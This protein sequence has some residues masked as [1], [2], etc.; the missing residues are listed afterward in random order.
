[1]R[2]GCVAAVLLFYTVACTAPAV[3]PLPTPTPDLDA[4]LEFRVRERV[5]VEVRT[6]MAQVPTATAIPT[7]TPFPTAT[8]IP[9]ATPAPTVTPYPTA[10]PTQRPT[11]TPRPT[12][13]R[14]PTP[15]PTATPTIADQSKRLEPWVVR[16]S[17]FDSIGTGF[18]IRDP[19]RSSDWYIVTNAHVVGGNDY[20]AVSWYYHGIPDL[21]RVRVLG[22]DEVTDVALLDVG[23]N[24]FDWSGTEYPNGL[25]YLNDWGDGIRI[26]ADVRQGAEVLA[27][28]FPVGGGGRT[29][30]S[31]IV[32]V[33]NVRDQPFSPGV[34]YI[35]TDTAI[36]P[37]NSG[38][39]LMTR[40]GEIIGMNTWTRTDLENVGYALPMREILSRF[41]ALKNGQRLI[42]ATPTPVPTLIPKADFTDGSFLAVLTWDDGWYNTNQDDSICVD[43]VW[44]SGNRYEWRG[45]CEFGGRERNGKFYAWY[46]QQWLEAY[47]IELENR[48]Y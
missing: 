19:S 36:N 22:V 12:A 48:P 42:A 46:R 45:Q 43:R 26:S 29:T 40:S 35:K 15:L 37:G 39:P 25:A 5:E 30:T 28:G 8:P 18:F 11:L 6:A 20:V 41:D 21:N 44:Q 38:G 32:S 9:T 7:V 17:T 23:P 31:G 14:R 33:A 10:T 27:M 24:D 1:M 34:G 2:T 47:V 3:A 4:T 16:V 13:T